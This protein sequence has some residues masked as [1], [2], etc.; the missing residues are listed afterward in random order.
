MISHPQ[1]SIS[2]LREMRSKEKRAVLL[3][4]ESELPYK[5]ECVKVIF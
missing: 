2:S 5:L 4:N 1:G 3:S